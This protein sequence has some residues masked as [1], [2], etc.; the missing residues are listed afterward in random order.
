M[1]F[2]KKF[3]QAL[4]LAVQ[5][6]TKPHELEENAHQ[7]FVHIANLANS[8]PNASIAKELLAFV[9]TLKTKISMVAAEGERDALY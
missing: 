3:V 5:D 1:T 6:L 7:C 9:Q 4:H 2:N 8:V